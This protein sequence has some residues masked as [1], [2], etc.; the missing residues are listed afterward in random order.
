M[1]T[2]GRG[3]GM[4]GY[5][6]QVAVDAEH[7]LIVAHEVTNV[8]HDRT[9]LFNMAEQAKEAIATEKLTVVADRGYFKGEE[10]LDCAEAG[11][12]TY[13]PKPQASGNL[14]KGLFG[15]RDFIYKAEDDEYECPAGDRLTYRFTREESGK[16]IRRYWT[17]AC[18]RCPI[19]SKCTMAQYRRV[20]AVG[21]TKR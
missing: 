13:L 20:S 15:K 7:H 5:N 17:S 16:M 4:V 6:V 2:S 18:F 12:T 11:I 9:Q 3:T 1:A 8:G 10:I 19:K 21:N 14:A